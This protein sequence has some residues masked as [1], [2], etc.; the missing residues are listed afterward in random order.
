M[1]IWRGGEGEEEEEKEEAEEEEDG[2]E[3]KEEIFALSAGINCV[4]PPETLF[5]QQ[6][7][8]RLK[9]RW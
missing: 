2:E 9:E 5:S 6:N 4:S 7:Y 1:K 8:R 3:N